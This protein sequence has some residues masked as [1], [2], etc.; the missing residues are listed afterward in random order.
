MYDVCIMEWDVVTTLIVISTILGI[1]LTVSELLAY[2][3]CN[4]NSIMQCCCH[5][6]HGEEL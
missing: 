6:C 2:S 5:E 1:L 3:K 4:S